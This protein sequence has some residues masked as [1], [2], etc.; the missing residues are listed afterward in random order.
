MFINNI[1]YNLGSWVKLELIFMLKNNL[2]KNYEL[3]RSEIQNYH[4]YLIN[5]LQTNDVQNTTDHIYLCNA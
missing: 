3:T 5:D 2:K 1:T 4:F